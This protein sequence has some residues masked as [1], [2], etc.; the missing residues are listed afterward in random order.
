M[1]NKFLLSAL[2]MVLIFI[3]SANPVMADQIYIPDANAFIMTQAMNGVNDQKTIVW[4]GTY[5]GG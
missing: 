4:N 1:I 5:G 3:I 2:T